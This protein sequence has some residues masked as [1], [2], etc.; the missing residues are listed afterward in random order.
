MYVE[1]SLIDK[2][3]SFIP[4]FMYLC[5]FIWW[6]VV[7]P[8]VEWMLQNKVYNAKLVKQKIKK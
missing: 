2:L 6:V 4:I 8:L 7:N 1:A 3:R 5:L